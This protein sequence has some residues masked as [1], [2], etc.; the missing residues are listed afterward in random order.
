MAALRSDPTSFVI[1]HR[2][3]SIRDADLILVIGQ[4]VRSHRRAGYPCGPAG[5]RR[6]I[7]AHD[8]AQFTG[9]PEVVEV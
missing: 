5:T 4:P 2:L 3:S 8:D 9:A 6:R 1:A 7:S